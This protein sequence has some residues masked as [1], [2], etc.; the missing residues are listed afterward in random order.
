[1]YASQAAG[2][3][4][5]AS[6]ASNALAIPSAA[7]ACS[8]CR[9]PTADA[10]ERSVTRS[11]MYASEVAGPT[12]TA[13]VPNNPLVIP[14]AASAWR[15]FRTRTAAREAAAA[16][17]G[18]VWSALTTPIA[19]T[20]RRTAMCGAATALPVWR[21]PTAPTDKC[22]PATGA[23]NDSGGGRRVLRWPFVLPEALS[24]P[25][26]SRTSA[27]SA[28]WDWTA[29]AHLVPPGSTSRLGAVLLAAA[30]D[31]GPTTPPL[32][33]AAPLRPRHW[34]L[35]HSAPSAFG[36]VCIAPLTSFAYLL[37]LCLGP[38]LFLLAHWV[39]WVLGS[40]EPAVDIDPCSGSGC[41]AGVPGSGRR[42]PT[43]TTHAWSCC[44]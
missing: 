39:P 5:T 11:E 44:A 15:A 32:G 27:A 14:S 18:S 6:A 30:G 34:A 3:T 2:P 10:M 12:R 28:H 22:A 35:E 26:C 29:Q 36:E 43:V 20:V 42:V 40:A 9:T 33:P 8:A 1:M 23:L 13:S 41:W 25:R 19:V 31:V 17:K 24:L 4:R 21:M 38:E 16:V 37:N 7:S